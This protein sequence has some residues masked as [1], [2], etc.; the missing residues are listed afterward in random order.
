VAFNNGQIDME[1][2]PDSNHKNFCSLLMLRS[3]KLRPTKLSHKIYRQNTAN[4]NIPRW[5]R[6]E[7]NLLSSIQPCLLPL[8][9]SFPLPLSLPTTSKA[10]SI[11]LSNSSKN[12]KTSNAD[13]RYLQTGRTVI[14]HLQQLHLILSPKSSFQGS[15]TV[16]PQLLKWSTQ[17]E[18]II[19]RYHHLRELQPG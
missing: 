12:S 15:K 9:L 8:P 2:Y 1:F 11:V 6:P 10:V 3:T 7:P 5:S 18:N 16:P 17:P 19:E 4:L 14:R 13:P